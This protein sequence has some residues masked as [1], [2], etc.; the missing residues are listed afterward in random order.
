M[1]KFVQ[2]TYSGYIIKIVLSESL[3]DG[4]EDIVWR[5]R[6]EP[7]NPESGKKAADL[8]SKAFEE[9]LHFYFIQ[10]AK[11]L[12]MGSIGMKILTS[13]INTISK[14]ISSV[15]HRIVKKLS[16]DQLGYVADFVEEH[17]L[18]KDSPVASTTSHET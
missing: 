3:S 13:G 6:N 12:K 11:E 10:P 17:L 16:P 1:E 4:T 8:L 14:L 9:N 15:A 5:L 7:N 2:N 18:F